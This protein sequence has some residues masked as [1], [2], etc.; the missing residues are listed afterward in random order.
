MQVEGVVEA[1]ADMT[2]HEMTVRLAGPEVPVS[3]VIRALNGAGYTVGEPRK[4]GE[5]G[6]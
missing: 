2:R 5:G 3:A 6:P 4:L 1:H